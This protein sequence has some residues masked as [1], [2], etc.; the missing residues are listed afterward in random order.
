MKNNSNFIFKLSIAFILILSSSFLYGQQIINNNQTETIKLPLKKIVRYFNDF[1]YHYLSDYTLNETKIDSTT[2]NNNIITIYFTEN[3]NYKST[4]ILTN[5]DKYQKT[6]KQKTFETNI[7]MLFK[8]EYNAETLKHPI[9]PIINESFS[10]NG[11][12]K[13]KIKI[14]KADENLT[15][16]TFIFDSFDKKHKQKFIT[17][18]SKGI[19]DYFNYTI[20]QIFI[21]ENFKRDVLNYLANSSKS[22]ATDT[23]P[24][25]GN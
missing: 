25:K 12:L 17:N 5:L 20:Q 6:L 9:K 24:T 7:L 16:L 23:V 21:T 19:D 22:D 14:K 18:F 15:K 4:I 3:K 10:K 13:W 11:K 8:G 1:N 2:Q